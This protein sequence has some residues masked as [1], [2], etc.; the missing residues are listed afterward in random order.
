MSLFTIAFIFVGS[1]CCSIGLLH[2]LIFLRRRDLKED[3]SFA[4]LA[5]AIG[6]SSF[7]EIGAFHADSLATHIPLLKGTLFVQCVLWI[8][9]TWFIHFYTK[10]SKR[11]L[12]A[13]ITACYALAILV[14]FF[15]PGSIL[16]REITDVKP[17]VLGS[18]EAIFYSQGPANPWRI[19]GDGAW[20]LLLAYAGYASY[21]FAVGFDLRKAI[22]FGTTIFL[23]LGLGYL[24]GTLID[25]GIADPP[26]LGSFLFLPLALIMS[27]SLAGDVANA[28]RLAEEIKIAEKRWRSLLE[29]VNLLIIGIDHRHRI[30]YANPFFLQHTGYS[31]AEIIGKSFVEMLPERYRPEMSARFD[32]IFTQRSTIRAE[33]MIAMVG[34]AGKVTQIQWSSVFLADP[35]VSGNKILGIGKD[36]TDQLGAERSRDQAIEEL[37]ALKVKLEQEN[38]S[39]K[40]IIHLQHGFEE[41][42]GNSDELLYVLG[43]ITQVAQTDSTVLI[44]GET[45]TGKELVAR[46]IHRESKRRSKPFIRVNCAAIP[47]DLFES[48]LF[49]HEAGAF[50]GATSLRKGK[51]ELAQGGV[52]FLDE[53]A[54]IPLAAQSKLLNV[55]QERVIERV[56]GSQGIE[57]DV[58]I[59]VATN[60]V[61]E[62]EVQEGRFRS[63]L[64]YRLNIYPI[65]IPSLRARKKDIALLTKHFITIFNRQFGKQIDSV[66]PAVLEQLEHYSWP[67]NVRELRNVIERAIITSDSKVLS[68]PEE[69]LSMVRQNQVDI[70]A[71]ADTLLP[72]SDVER[73]HSRRA[74]EAT[75]WQIS[76]R[77]GAAAIL[78]MN[79]STLRSRIKK[80][81]LEKP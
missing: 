45:G 12:P 1:V 16:F 65:T 37:E 36:I 19:I 30:F 44:Q 64:Y 41:I 74:L 49:G 8:S 53:I 22:F 42:V 81:N 61:L 33:R 72:L 63:D 3:L 2:L 21:R 69:T 77:E 67:G 55:M 23:C 31:Q 54:E 9:F 4:V 47:G 62:T 13:L 57:L 50:T 51:F 35:D 18:G 26:Y 28:S 14:N 48:E 29:N 59:L 43:K 17:F 75:N 7:F 46:A 11:W 80:H 24:H 38:V 10:S 39:L 73:L 56:G 20:F 70:T 78:K 66:E 68:L 40:E 5:I 34:R 76:G 58:H 27:Y 6:F 60:R 32:E 71:V 79:P 25:L 15:S 52:L